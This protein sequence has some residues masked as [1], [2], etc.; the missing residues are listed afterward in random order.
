MQESAAAVKV[1]SIARRNQTMSQIEA[2]GGSTAAIRN[3]S[4]AKARLAQKGKT[5]HSDDAPDLMACC[6]IGFLFG[7][8]NTENDQAVLAEERRKEYQVMKRR[9]ELIEEERRKY[10]HRK[11][12]SHR[13]N[14]EFEVLDAI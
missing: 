12:A 13:M 5:F 10:R 6:G 14:E 7:D 2:M 4:R 11:K 8:T 3:R 9:E 1:Q